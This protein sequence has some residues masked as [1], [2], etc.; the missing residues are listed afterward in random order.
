MFSIE[1]V[2]LLRRKDTF[3]LGFVPLRYLACYNVCVCV[4]VV[5]VCVWCVRVCVCVLFI[6][7][8]KYVY[9][10]VYKYVYKYMPLG[11]LGCF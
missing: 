2:L 8:Y 5:C 9:I 6:Y 11:Y 4:C 7:V 10:Y 3:I 1:C